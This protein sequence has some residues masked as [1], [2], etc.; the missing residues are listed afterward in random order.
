[1]FYNFWFFL[2]NLGSNIGKLLIYSK[3]IQITYVELVDHL[4]FSF[5]LSLCLEVALF[6]LLISYWLHIGFNFFSS[7]KL[8][9][10]HLL[11]G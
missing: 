9:I 6:S 10:Y 11:H 2:F 7:S 3:I 1:M 4:T 8:F 5:Q